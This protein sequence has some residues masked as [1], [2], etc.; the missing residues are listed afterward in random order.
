MGGNAAA[1]RPIVDGHLD[2]AEN[3]TI[4]GWDLTASIDGLRKSPVDARWV[5]TVSLPELARG[6]IAVA[7]ATVTAGFNV[8][9]VG[10]DF[11]P[12]SGLYRTYEEAEAQALRQVALYQRWEAEGRVRLLR[13]GADLSRHLLRWQRDRKPGLVM[14]M[15]GADP[16]CRIEDL[17]QWWDRGVRLIAL[18]YGD[19]RYGTGVGSGSTT[20]KT[21]GLTQEGVH[22]L[23]RMNEVGFGWDVSHL[24][25]E[26]IRQ[27]LDLGYRNVCAT[28][29]NARALVPT[30]RQL[31]DDVLRR[32]AEHD[33]V[34]GLVL[35]NRFL[36]PT[37]DRS[38]G[39][40]LTLGGAFR[41]HAH[42]IA[43]LVG[44]AHVGIGSDLDGGLGRE[45]SPAEIDTIAD[46]GKIG[47]VVPAE[48]AAA[49]LGGNWIRFLAAV[50]PTS[51]V[52]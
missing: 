35:Y 16:V 3:V 11:E 5:P 17:P 32:I 15:E 23:E 22:L 37:W 28:H 6:G 21:G 26:G 12:R 27:G 39:A 29:A 9:D 19:T 42:H 14:V 44:W 43:S 30:D 45:E 46:L 36:D 41:R 52:P 18:T 24:A 33:G 1:A 8:E 13:S 34:V 10:V 20:F 31:S 7:L 50:L 2:L 47:E 40:S 25:D 48:H 51:E 49:V 38:N 4:F